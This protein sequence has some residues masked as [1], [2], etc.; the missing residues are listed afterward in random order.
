MKGNSHVAFYLTVYSEFSSFRGLTLE[1]ILHE[2][3]DHDDTVSSIFIEPPEANT[4]SDDDS[5]DEIVQ[6]LS[7][8]VAYNKS[9]PNYDC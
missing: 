7:I 6:E 9:A 2:F 4:A 3:G 1:E 8:G 5:A